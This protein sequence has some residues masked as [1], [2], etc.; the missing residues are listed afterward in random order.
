MHANIFMNIIVHDFVHGS[1]IKVFIEFH[2]C[3]ICLGVC[4]VHDTVSITF[5][6]S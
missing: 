1:L 5:E 2:A 4:Y 3:L 6:K